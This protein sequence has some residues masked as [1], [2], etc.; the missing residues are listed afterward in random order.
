[1]K[2]ALTGVPSPS[3]E[4]APERPVRPPFP[5]PTTPLYNTLTPRL[6]PRARAHQ[7]THTRN[8]NALHSLC[9]DKTHGTS[10]TFA[11]HS[12]PR[13]GPHL[14]PQAAILDEAHRLKSRSS[15]TRLAL[16]DL[17]IH[18]LL[19][20]SGTPVQNNMKELQV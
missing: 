11:H 17:N 12:R 1:M 10:H 8:T 18:W 5:P 6:P 2:R 16:E 15:A 9:L 20:L 14:S 3:P 19:L 7:N 13:P 4:P